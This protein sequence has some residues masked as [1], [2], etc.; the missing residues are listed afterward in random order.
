MGPMALWASMMESLDSW[1]LE[2]GSR[3]GYGTYAP[4]PEVTEIGAAMAGVESATAP[5]CCGSSRRLT[6]EGSH[7]TPTPVTERHALLV[8]AFLAG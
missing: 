4:A 1:M 7:L 8:V 2:V 3:F 6:G 5:P